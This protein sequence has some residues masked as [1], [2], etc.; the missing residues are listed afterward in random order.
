MSV[1]E[2]NIRILIFFAMFETSKVKTE[3]SGN[4]HE[5]FSHVISLSRDK[6]TFLILILNNSFD[7]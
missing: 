3:N 7:A 2:L 5:Q 4:R 6:M 1:I